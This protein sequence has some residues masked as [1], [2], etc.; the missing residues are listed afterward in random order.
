MGGTKFVT[1]TEQTFNIKLEPI[2]KEEFDKVI[3]SLNFDG[4]DITVQD[5][6]N[7]DELR[8]F[9]N[10]LEALRA[11]NPYM[12]VNCDCYCDLHHH[13]TLSLPIR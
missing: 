10:E 13:D 2:S 4:V 1:A 9:D 7:A 11:L 3:S 6:K 8:K 5:S 12:P